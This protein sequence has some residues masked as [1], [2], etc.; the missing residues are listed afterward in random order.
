MH[1]LESS[2]TAIAR[3]TESLF[4]IFAIGIVFEVGKAFLSSAG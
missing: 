3:V 4:F 2:N 1:G